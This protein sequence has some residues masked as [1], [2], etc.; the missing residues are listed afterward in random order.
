VP[1]WC[2]IRDRRGPCGASGLSYVIL[3]P[4]YFIQNVFG[5]AE[6]IMT[7]GMMFQGTG[8]GRLG[9]IDVRDIADVAV[10]VLLDH[11]WDRGIYELTGPASISFH[12]QFAREVFAPALAR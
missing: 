11:S 8:D 1:D 12:D 9:F 5:S 2:E 10:A 7:S 3:R 4:N 6:S